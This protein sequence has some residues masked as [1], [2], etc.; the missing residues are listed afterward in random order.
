MSRPL[1]GVEAPVH[2]A[3][4][5]ELEETR[6]AYHNLLA[7]LSPGDWQRKSDNP[8]WTVGELMYHITMAHEF[9]PPEARWIVHRR[10]RF[11]VPASIFNPL[12]MLYTRLMARR[13]SA[14]TIGRKFDREHKRVLDLL[15]SL[16]A[17]QLQMGTTYPNIGRSLPG[18]F[19]TIEEMFHY[20]TQHFHEHA[21]EIERGLAATGVEALAG[22]KGLAS[23]RPDRGL[24][25]L[26]LRFPVKL[27]RARLGW[28]LGD[29]FLMLSHKGRKSGKW[30]QAVLEVVRHDRGRG[31]YVVA[32]GWG[33]RA[34][35]LQNIMQTPGVVVQVGNRRFRAVAARLPLE[36]AAR[37][38]HD[39][40][41]K[42]PL[43]FRQLS[44]LLMGSSRRLDATMAD[45]TALAK[46]VP[47]VE[48][49]PMRAG[50]LLTDTG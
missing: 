50:D 8:G 17:E 30:H 2:D 13:Y 49:R 35:W 41:V 9:L 45:C 14:R 39:Y 5:N 1:G 23:T 34:D 19:R 11:P 29:R 7:T 10:P 3:I 46:V 33:E 48:L 40:A 22:R 20:L 24:L 44:G 15:D 36:Q 16:S 21:A 42:H 32:S 25:K 6:A 27:Y 31:S 47:L 43:A 26:L 4:R 38:L 18:G 28:L 37:T 12:N